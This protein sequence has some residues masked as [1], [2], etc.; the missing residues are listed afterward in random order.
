[1]E[2][3]YR[4]RRWLAR[5]RPRAIVLVDHFA[6]LTPR[7]Q[8][9]VSIASRFGTSSVYAYPLDEVGEARAMLNAQTLAHILALP[10]V[11]HRPKP[12]SSV[13]SGQ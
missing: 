7:P 1:M 5:Q 9:V 13:S 10:L 4:F 6:Q 3:W 12:T 8:V 11:D 2:L